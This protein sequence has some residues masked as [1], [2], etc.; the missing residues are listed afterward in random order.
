MKMLSVSIKDLQV[1]LKDRGAVIL[2]F[3]LP[4]V[5]IVAMAF[6]SQ[7]ANA[8]ASTGEEQR[9]P[10]V[11]V[12]EDTAGA[13]AGSASGAATGTAAAQI[14]AGLEN[15][16]KFILQPQDAARTESQLNSSAI[17]IALFIP[18]NF[19]AD[20]AAGKQTSL[21]LALHPLAKEEDIMT[22]ERNLAR[23]IRE[24]LMM[25]YLDKA[26]QQ[27]ADMQAANP[28]AANAFSMERIQQQVAQ[29]QAQAAK[30]PLVT[31]AEIS[32][33][34]VTTTAAAEALPDV[35]QVTVLG[36]AV[37]FVFLGAQTTALSIFKE[38]KQGS[39]RRLMAAPIH[40]PSL[41]GGKLLPGVILGLVQIAVIFVTGGF[42]IQLLGL[43]PLDLASDPL[44]LVVISLA[45]VLCSASLGLFIVSIARTENQVSGLST[46][47]LF[48]AG[49]LSGS[50]IPL[51]L[52][53]QGLENI[54][55]L[56]PQYWANQAF[57][58]LVFRGQT[59]AQLWPDVLVLLAFTLAFFG[60]GLW[61]FKFD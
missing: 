34:K 12:N 54:A 22:V 29:Q 36:M 55:R 2:L 33:V 32:P 17:R 44:G 9:L 7:Q 11:V 27:M 46:A 59:L 49:I 52:F 45:T 53:P 31:V 56:L 61:R 23:V 14:L 13:T 51:F 25:V 58:G 35:G 20:V 47:L 48:A 41:L 38:K 6:F 37:L 8:S 40:K 50:F 60:I 1:F 43:K 21:R 5:F 57:F 28:Q 18:P 26:L 16:G 4:F 19:S 24:Y 3:L 10:L 39:F 42:F 15:T 30:R